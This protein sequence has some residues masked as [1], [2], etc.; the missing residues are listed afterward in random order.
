MVKLMGGHEFSSPI[1]KGWTPEN[2]EMKWVNLITR[3]R[4]T[5]MDRSHL[6]QRKEWQPFD[7][8]S[9]NSSNDVNLHVW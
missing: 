6:K 7:H 8:E 2:G 5:A 1:L 9:L 4:S 3:N